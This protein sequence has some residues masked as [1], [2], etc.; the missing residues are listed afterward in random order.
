M[1]RRTPR[2]TIGTARY[3][4]PTPADAP[5]LLVTFL[6]AAIIP[7]AL[8]AV[9]YPIQSATLAVVVAAAALLWQGAAA[10]LRRLADRH[11]RLNVPGL[12]VDV[13]FSRAR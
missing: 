1:T 12:D 11:A 6:M 3:D 10:A 7:V 9:S 4:T 13:A 2:Y 5:S 8:V